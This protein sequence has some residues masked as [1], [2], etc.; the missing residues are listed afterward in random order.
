MSE[1]LH[2]SSTTLQDTSAA[3]WK[4][5]L[6]T[7]GQGSSGFYSEAVLQRDGGRAFPS[8]T[9]SYIDHPRDGES[10]SA[11]NLFGVLT[12]DAHFEPGVGLVATLAVLPHWQA[13]SEAVAPH[14]GLSIYASAERTRGADGTYV[15]ESILPD[16]S[17]TVDVVGFPGRPGSGLKHPVDEAAVEHLDKLYES[18]M[19][20]PLPIAPNGQSG[21][22]PDALARISEQV[23]KR[24]AKALAEEAGDD[25]SAADLASG[26]DAAL[27]E[28]ID[29]F[30]SVDNTTLDTNVQQ[31][32]NLVK[33]ADAAVDSL[34]EVL[35]L[36]DPDE[37]SATSAE[38]GPTSVGVRTSKK[39]KTLEI[40]EIAGKVDSLA[41]ALAALTAIVKPLV[42][43]MTPA[44]EQVEEQVA[45]DFALVAEACVTAGLPEAARKVVY[46]EVR[47]GVDPDV[48]IANQKTLVESIEA[49]VTE[50]LGA[51]RVRVGTDSPNQDFT[52]HNSKWSVTR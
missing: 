23:A 4:A 33:A 43:N 24:F 52:L 9:H 10:R 12:E 49:S 17:N 35:G 48:A 2:E 46:S 32:I 50:S 29:L 25:E 47:N 22:T 51:A 45:I 41:E 27:D 13:F 44:E 39:E 28:A 19:N 36:P 6:I 31:G 34:L 40:T 38:S 8:G 18:A 42:E 1:I 16:R 37:S 3:K 14:V 5:V 15:V 30:A 7:P 20:S 21:I 26:I 11:K